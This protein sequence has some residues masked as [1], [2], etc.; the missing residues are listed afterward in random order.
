MFDYIL[1]NL[2]G[3]LLFLNQIFFKYNNNLLLYHHSRIISKSSIKKNLLE[4]HNNFFQ[5][6][7]LIN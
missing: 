5:I 4:T 1:S 2:L 6:I 3:L 7:Q